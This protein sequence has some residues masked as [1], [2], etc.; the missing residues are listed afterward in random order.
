MPRELVDLT[1]IL[2]HETSKA[3]GVKQTEDA[4]EL[5]WLAKSQVEWVEV[6]GNIIEVTLPVWL[7]EEKG[8][9]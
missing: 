2:G 8:L 7:A 6:K 4:K 1:L 3:I 9:V 5:K